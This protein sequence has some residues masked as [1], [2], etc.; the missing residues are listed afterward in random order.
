[1]TPAKLPDTLRDVKPRK[2]ADTIIGDRFVLYS[3]EMVV[4]LEGS[5]YLYADAEL[6]LTSPLPPL[7]LWVERRE[8]GFHVTVDEENGWVP[9][10]IGAKEVIIPVV[11]ITIT[12]KAK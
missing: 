2:V 5:C 6:K 1:M 12:K 7:T 10:E 9:R 3:V 11:S 8:D 4:D